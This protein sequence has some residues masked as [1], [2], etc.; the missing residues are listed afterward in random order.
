MPLKNLRDTAALYYKNLRGWRT[1]R[2]IVVIESDDWGSIRMP[3]REVYEKCLKA[4]YPV[5]KI[6]YERYDS[7]LS[8]D[9]LTALFEVL[10]KHKD[11]KGNN[12]LITANALV[13][14]PDFKK[15]KEADFKKYHYELITDTFERYPQHSKAFNLW[16]EGISNR[17]IKPQF[18]GRE[19]L[20]VA[21]FMDALKKGDKD[22]HFGFQHEMPGCIPKGPKVKGNTYVE[23]T[24]FRSGAEK[25]H[26]KLFLLEGLNLFEQIFG[27]RS[28][29][30]IPTNYTW[31]Q[32]LNKAMYD[33]GVRA[34][35]GL[36]DMRE[37]HLNGKHSRIKH[38]M[39]Q[40]ND[41]GQRYLIRNAVFEPSLFKMGISN[42]AGNCL[43]QINVAFKMKKPAIITA[44]RINFCG[45]ID[46]K[47]RTNN[48]NA[49]DKLLRTII[50]KWPS[51]VFISS[52]NLARGIK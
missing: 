28:E 49:L 30:Y 42:P 29:T 24:R 50:N 47:N 8:E 38:F 26:V 2:K 1:N 40:E 18:H 19:H 14:N 16:K 15:I 3:S 46:E 9:D 21:M 37:Q 11:S 33:G 36:H 25:D 41:L 4:G 35:Q 43:R 51:V 44:H 48:L 32:D 13:A 34:F 27:Y 17:L 22:A 12:P 39:G 5:D 10:V 7:L 31:N 45:Y 20:N 52:D 6:A 23:A